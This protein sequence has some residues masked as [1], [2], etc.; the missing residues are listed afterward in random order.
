MINSINSHNQSQPAFKA[1]MRNTFSSMITKLYHDSC[2]I[3]GDT[4]E[5][6]NMIRVST[7]LDNGKTIS[8]TVS[9]CNGNYAGLKLDEGQ[10]KYRG[11]FIKNIMNKYRNNT[12]KG[13]TRDRLGLNK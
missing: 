6:S 9:F 7:T 1:H 13:H 2:K 3:A 10:E 11:E 8:G 12:A 4:F 5:N